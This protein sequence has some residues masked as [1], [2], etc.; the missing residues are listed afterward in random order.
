[1]S[2]SQSIYTQL[3]DNMEFYRPPREEHSAF[4]EIAYGCSWAGCTFCDFIKD[5]YKVYSLKDVARKAQLLSQVMEGR[6][7]IHFLGC[8]PLALPTD[9]L[10]D[11]FMLTRRYIPQATEYSMYARAEDVLAKGDAGL[12]ALRRAGL[13]DVHMG[14]ESGSDEILAMH[15]KGETVSQM[16][17]TASTRTTATMMVATR[18]EIMAFPMIASAPGIS[19]FFAFHVFFFEVLLLALDDL[20]RLPEV[21]AVFPDALR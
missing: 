14:V 7:R 10:L 9:Y 13:T 17:P 4:L 5:E 16:P 3:Y 19:T 8:N 21:L 1:M 15:H 12:A 2:D 18:L 20:T 6:T 11:V